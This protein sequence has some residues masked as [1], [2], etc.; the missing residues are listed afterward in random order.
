MGAAQNGL[1]Q[2]AEATM[3]DG[4]HA[5]CGDRPAEGPWAASDGELLSQ[6]AQLAAADERERLSRD[7]HDLVL[8]RLFGLAA[9]LT[10]LSSN[11][12]DSRAAERLRTCVGDLDQTIDAIRD[13][14][15]HQPTLAGESARPRPCPPAAV[16]ALAEAVVADQRPWP[17]PARPSPGWRALRPT[18]RR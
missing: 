16:V 6:Y 2:D 8:Q 3:G 13:G 9:S 18:A 4:P 17:T 1:D 14:I 15:L 5:A 11:I 12:S 7:L 10:A